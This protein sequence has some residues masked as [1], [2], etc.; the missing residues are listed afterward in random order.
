MIGDKDGSFTKL[1]IN[2]IRRGEKHQISIKVCYKTD[3]K[4]FQYKKWK[5]RA[6]GKIILD[7]A[8]ILFG[9]Q[10][11]VIPLLDVLLDGDDIP[12]PSFVR[13]LKASSSRHSA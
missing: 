9:R 8:A 2:R 12:S 3:F 4:V 10:K 5:N 13:A 11:L 7:P 6:Q 1:F